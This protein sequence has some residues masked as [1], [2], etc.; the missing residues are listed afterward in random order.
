MADQS[1]IK[2]KIF[3]VC[4]SG[5]HLFEMFALED[6]WKRYERTWVC[7]SST[8]ARYLLKDETTVW[9]HSPTN[10][11]IPNLFRNAFLAWRLI[12]SRK[13]SLIL[14][15]G[16]GVA[17]PFII[18]G[19]LFGIRTVYVES[20]TRITELSLTGWLVYPFVY[21]FIVQWPELA[22]KHRK[23]EYHGR[24]I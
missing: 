19:N 20:I 13:P 12:R 15:T 2:Q 23:A 3:L 8:D 21:K 5:G 16:A 11:N 1:L 24:I 18:I 22:R 9:A 6:F 4:S 17:V 14:S 10:R 7:F